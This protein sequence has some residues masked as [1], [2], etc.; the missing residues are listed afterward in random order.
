MGGGYTD[1][2]DG[3]RTGGVPDGNFMGGRF[4]GQISGL[5]GYIGCT[6]FYSRPLS[7]GEILNN[8]NATQKF[9]KNIDLT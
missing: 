2:I 9:F 8:Y 6:R 5:R 4:G 7:D 3:G 1:G